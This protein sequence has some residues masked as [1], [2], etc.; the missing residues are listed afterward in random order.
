MGGENHRFYR[1]SPFLLSEQSF[2]STAHRDPFLGEKRQEKDVKKRKKD[3]KSGCF[4][5]TGQSFLSVPS[6]LIF[7]FSA[8]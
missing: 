5:G 6:S 3:V 7:P 8:V 1:F 2:L 4:I